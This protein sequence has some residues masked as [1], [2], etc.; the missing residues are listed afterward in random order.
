MGTSNDFMVISLTTVGDT[1]WTYRYNGSANNWDIA[2]SIVYGSDG[3]LYVAGYASNLVTSK[4]FTV[5]SL[6]TT[7]A[8]NWVYGYSAASSFYWDEAHS[9]AYGLD[10]NIYAAGY[11]IYST[12]AGIWDFTVISLGPVGVEEETR[13]QKPEA[14]LMIYP[15]PFSKLIHI[16]FGKGPSAECIELKIYDASGRLVKD[17]NLKSEISNL[18]SEVSWKGDDNAGQMLPCGVY[19]LEFEAGDY[20]ETRKLLVIR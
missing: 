6:D 17:F 8:E 16:S 3:N 4:D 7:G 5:I 1:N 9:V 19:F 15:N 13:S 18:Q 11:S 10:G 20:K 2:K 12:G 14:R